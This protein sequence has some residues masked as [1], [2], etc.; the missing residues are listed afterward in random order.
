MPAFEGTELYVNKMVC[1]I[2][3]RFLLMAIII[4]ADIY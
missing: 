2:S 1:K 3:L 4:Y